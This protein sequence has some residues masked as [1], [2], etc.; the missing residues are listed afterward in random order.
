MQGYAR[1]NKKGEPVMENMGIPT[2]ILYIEILAN[3][4]VKYWRE[5]PIK[6]NT[7]EE[8]IKKVKLECEYC[9]EENNTTVKISLPSQGYCDQENNTT[10]KVSPLEEFELHCFKG[11]H[12]CNYS[13]NYTP[14]IKVVRIFVSLHKIPLLRKRKIVF[15][16]KISS[17]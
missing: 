3:D 16:H 17:Q 2:I 1:I 10:V 14:D 5:R 13:I 15:V 12:N 11:P 4:H 6:I 9:K 7:P 8:F